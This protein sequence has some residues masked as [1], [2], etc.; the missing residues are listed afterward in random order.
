[1]VGAEVP[2]QTGELVKRQ[3]KA[4]S[5]EHDV[6]SDSAASSSQDSHASAASGENNYSG[7][8]E[9]ES[10]PWFSMA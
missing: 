4:S 2:L 5:V 9:F 8:R 1:M 3:A 6:S 10:I 7:E